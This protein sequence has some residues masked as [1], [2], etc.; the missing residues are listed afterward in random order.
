VTTLVDP[1]VLWCVKCLFLF[2]LFPRFAF[3][4]CG[5]YF[6]L[7]RLMGV[8]NLLTV[9][10]VYRPPRSDHAKFRQFQPNCLC[11][12]PVLDA[13]GFVLFRHK[14]SI[15]PVIAVC[16]AFFWLNGWWACEFWVNERRTC[17][18]ALFFPVRGGGEGELHRVV[19]VVQC[20]PLP[21]SRS[22]LI[23][24]PTLPFGLHVE[25]N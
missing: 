6:L 21:L 5:L 12:S 13:L 19:G 24:S 11:F 2:V 16:L 8:M 20:M 1:T 9:R 14:I 7:P 15:P 10:D 17:G 3:C 18:I 4:A 25:R 22:C 23:S